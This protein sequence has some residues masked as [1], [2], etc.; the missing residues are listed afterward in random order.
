[1]TKQVVRFA[2]VGVLSTL[3][4]LVLFVLLRSV[5]GA[6]AANFVALA[7]TAIANT[8]ANR[9]LTFGVRGRSGAVRHQF[10]GFGVFLVGLAITSG[11]L[12]LLARSTRTRPTWWRSPSWC[13]QTSRPPS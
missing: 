5:T 10:Q 11:S 13:W 7:L 9:R 1:M 6:Q 8:A 3:A 2:A 4:Y 12:A